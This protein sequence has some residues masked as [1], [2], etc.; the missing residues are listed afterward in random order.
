MDS[1]QSVPNHTIDPQT[2]FVESLAYPDAFDAMRK[3]EFLKF[4]KESGLG[5]WEACERLGVSH[6]TVRKHYRIDPEFKKAFDEAKLEY[7]DKLEAL[8]RRTALNPK[9]TI[10]RI[11]QL[12]ALVPERYADQKGSGR[13]EVVI[14]IS[15]EALENAQKRE[16]MIDAKIVE[17]QQERVLALEGINNKS[18]MNPQSFDNQTI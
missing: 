12:K 17:D 3:A 15:Q 9:A 10:E 7:S 13:V 18:T 14:N 16:K 5:I 6:N 2:G 1:L 8:S 11:F 4:Y